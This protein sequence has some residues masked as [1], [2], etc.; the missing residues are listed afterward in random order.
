MANKNISKAIVIVQHQLTP[1]AKQAVTEASP[2]IEME[3]PA[4]PCSSDAQR[5][6]RSASSCFRSL[7][8][9]LYCVG[10][11]QKHIPVWTGH[12]HTTSVAMQCG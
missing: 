12:R 2:K 3:V 8:P 5:E 10:S 9:G 7:E 4:R 1:F 6:P 11:G